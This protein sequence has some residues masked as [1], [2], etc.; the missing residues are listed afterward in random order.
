MTSKVLALPF[1]AAR[2]SVRLPLPSDETV[3]REWLRS[4]VRW[5]TEGV[6]DGAPLV[7]A[8][9]NLPH[10]YWKEFA[11]A[12]AHLITIPALQLLLAVAHRDL[13]R[14]VKRAARLIDF[15]TRLIGQTE[16]P[17]FAALSRVRCYALLYKE[18]ANLQRIRGQALRSLYSARKAER[19]LRPFPLLEIEIGNI[20]LLQA[21]IQHD[22]KRAPEAFRLLESARQIF[23]QHR[24]VRHYL[25]TQI[26][27]GV[28]RFER[29]E[30]SEAVAIFEDS[31]VAARDADEPESVARVHNNLGH[32][33]LK[34]EPAHLTRA[35][36]H[37]TVALGRFDE[38]GMAVERDRALWG[39]ARTMPD[40]DVAVVQ[41][42]RVRDE[43]LEQ[44]L[45]VEAALAGVDLI[46]LLLLAK[47]PDRVTEAVR[48]Q[49][50]L[51]TELRLPD[52]VLAAFT[53]L[54][55]ALSTRRLTP[56]LLHH[57]WAYVR[58]L[59]TEPERTFS[60]QEIVSD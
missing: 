15:V 10:A 39:L 13:D 54:Q 32:T 53:F 4:H 12:N 21:H 29:H 44:S 57:V 38:L 14:D 18:R 50:R 36:T 42:T 41:L 23:R 8:V 3:S 16:V 1:R 45:A 7:A 27:E 43:F 35:V 24:D 17:E 51:F 49:V 52:N 26:L 30:Y 55:Q 46:T 9:S 11:R 2:N 37:L 48:E 25:F 5:S 60:P 59:R 56:E 22:R 28:M 40:V 33:L 58:A 6:R 20:L 19:I 34:L 31:L 47:Q